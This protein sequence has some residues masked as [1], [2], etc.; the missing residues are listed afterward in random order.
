MIP[1]VSQL[2]EIVSRVPKE[3]NGD[4]DFLPFKRDEE[5]LVRE[6]AIPGMKGLEHRIGG[7]EKQDKTGN[8]SYDPQN[9]EFMCKVRAEKIARIANFIP[10]QK[11]IGEESGELLVVGWG[12]TYGSLLTA[13]TEMQEDG[14]N[15]SLAHFNY[16]NP[17]PKNT[18]AILKRFKKIVVCELNLGQFHSYLIS[19]F[20]DQHMLKFNKV[21]G[22]PFMIGELRWH[23]ESILAGGI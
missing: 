20:P 8:V 14:K 2:P 5:T 4:G 1:D 11:V 15:I 23:F 10:E 12:G 21:Q 9:H 13:V 19:N 22:L 18:E 17:L 7:L 16:I 3:T 6:W